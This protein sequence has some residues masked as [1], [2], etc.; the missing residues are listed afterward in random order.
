MTM[1]KVKVD[2][3]PSDSA[4]V[5]AGAHRG[6]HARVCKWYAG[7]LKVVR[8]YGMPSYPA[9]TILSACTYC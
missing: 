5:L 4:A 6:M 8:R 9:G 3:M 2:L 7:S 1:G